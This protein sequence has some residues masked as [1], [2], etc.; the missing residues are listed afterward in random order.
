MFSILQYLRPRV[1]FFKTWDVSLFAGTSLGII[2]FGS[3][4]DAATEGTHHTW[5][6]GGVKAP[7]SVVL[8]YL[9]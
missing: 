8:A 4:S 9:V 6:Q 1:F 5:L 2:R 3:I 7:V